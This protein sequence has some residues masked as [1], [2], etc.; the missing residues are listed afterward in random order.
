[1]D[2]DDVVAVCLDN[3]MT[4]FNIRL[5]IHKTS[6]QRRVFADNTNIHT[7]IQYISKTFQKWPK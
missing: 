6:F 5:N 4:K 2:S 3:D 7:Y 1:M